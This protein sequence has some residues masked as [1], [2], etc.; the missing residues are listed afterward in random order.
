MNLIISV[1]LSTNYG[2]QLDEEEDCFE[3]L[4]A[5]RGK[6]VPSGHLITC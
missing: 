4:D 3:N 1:L 2:T 6:S 5:G